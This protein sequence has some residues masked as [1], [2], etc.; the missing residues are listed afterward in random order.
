MMHDIEPNPEYKNKI[1]NNKTALH[2]ASIK[3]HHKKLRILLRH[4]FGKYVYTGKSNLHFSMVKNDLSRY[5]I[6]RV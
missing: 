5:P 4:L 1:D 3:G 2:V 6:V